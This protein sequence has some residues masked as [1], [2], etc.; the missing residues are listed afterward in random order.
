[1]FVFLRYFVY[2][3]FYVKRY[4]IIVIDVA[5][6][7]TFTHKQL[8]DFFWLLQTMEEKHMN[9]EIMEMEMP[10]PAKLLDDTQLSREE[11]L[12]KAKQAISEEVSFCHEVEN[13]NQYSD[14][15]VYLILS[16]ADCSGTY[17]KKDF[18]SFLKN[19]L[20]DHN[21]LRNWLREHHWKLHFLADEIR[22][23]QI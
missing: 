14:G 8:R 17:S 12:R 1:M 20:F 4:I 13:I 5:I 18:I 11:L 6:L 19:P 23:I 10:T 2:L 9:I 3:T 22:L 16:F 7:V 21:G 15:T